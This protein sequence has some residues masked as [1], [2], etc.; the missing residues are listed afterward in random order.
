[1]TAMRGALA[2]RLPVVDPRLERYLVPGARDPKGLFELVSDRWDLIEYVP[3]ASRS[4]G[5]YRVGF[6]NFETWLKAYAKWYVHE[7]L[8]LGDRSLAGGQQLIAALMRSDRWI[9]AAGVEP[10]DLAGTDAFDALWL[11]LLG[12]WADRPGE[13]PKGAIWRQVVSRPFW[14]AMATTF[15]VPKRVPRVAAYRRVS[16][17]VPAAD[18]ERVIPEPV[19]RQLVNRLALHRDGSA[20]ASERDELRLCVVLLHVIL[21]RRISELLAC[22]RLRGA[23]GP[24]VEYTDTSGQPA[25]GFRFRPSKGGGNDNVVYISSAWEDIARYC[26]TRILAIGDRSRTQAPAADRWRLILA[27]RGRDGSVATLNYHSLMRWLN[28]RADRTAGPPGALERWSITTDGTADSAV[29]RLR[30][31]AARHT[32]SSALA[33]DPNVSRLA[34]ARDLN[35]RS[36]EIVSVYQHGIASQNEVLRQRAARGELWGRGAAWVEMVASGGY[37][38]GTPRVLSLEPRIARLIEQ[39]PA[40][41]EFNRVETGYCV[42]PQGPSACTEYLQCV[43]TS[44]HGCAW[45]ATDPQDPRCLDELDTR[46]MAAR[47]EVAQAAGAGQVVLTGKL[48]ILAA[49]AQEMRDEVHAKA[50][51]EALDR[52]RD[53]LGN[54]P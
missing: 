16:I 50:S 34:A 27:K 47:E 52:L 19:I 9:A 37:T 43:E 5:M 8:I 45:F 41:V 49:R 42:R 10:I 6:R 20:P 23:G 38:A 32:R 7:H 25:L 30:T 35:D 11:D 21:G 2:L 1:V 4:A 22:P 39:N 3:G 44:H 26:V 29:Y 54:R 13:R 33:R 31:H 15:D 28:G 48:A 51:E 36:L 40:F 53:Y 24:L 18:D 46:S 17:A 14:T 12:D